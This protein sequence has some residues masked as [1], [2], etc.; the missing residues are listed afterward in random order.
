MGLKRLPDILSERI[1]VGIGKLDHRETVSV[2]IG[3]NRFSIQTLLSGKHLAKSKDK[4]SQLPITIKWIRGL[5]PG[6]KNSTRRR[7]LFVLH[8]VE[9]RVPRSLD[10]SQRVGRRCFVSQSDGV[11]DFP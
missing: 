3:R 5:F 6:G 11:P 1:N 9:K 2:E 10:G 4:E 8:K 7:L